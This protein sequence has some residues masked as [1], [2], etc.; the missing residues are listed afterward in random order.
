MGALAGV[1]GE[2]EDV[3]G[4]VG[5]VVVGLPPPVVMEFSVPAG[6]RMN[7]VSTPFVVVEARPRAVWWNQVVPSLVRSALV[8]P[9]WT[10]S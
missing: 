10:R 2:A 3:A 1:V 8:V 6:S 4:G 7:P 5:E 9:A